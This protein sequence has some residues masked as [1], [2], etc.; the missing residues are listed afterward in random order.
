M[1]EIIWG[2]KTAALMDV[3]TIEHILSGLS[4][5][6]GVR[7]KNHNVFLKKLGLAKESIQTKYFDLLGVLFLAYAWE[8]IEHYLETGLAGKAVEFWFQ[9]VEFWG[10][11][12]IFD[13]LML[14]L[15][16]FIARK[17]PKLVLPARLLSLAWLV[18]HVLFFP[19]SMYLH[20]L[21]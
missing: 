20:E 12:I 1:L 17:Y 19:H 6:Q 16:Y 9:G 11:R 3:W 13:P 21:L 10:N 15:G 2:L 8:T 7:K 18:T 4:V 5:G 14:V